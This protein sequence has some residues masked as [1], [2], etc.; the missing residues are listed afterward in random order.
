M[1]APVGPILPSWG[2]VG[3]I[4]VICRPWLDGARGGLH[5]PDLAQT[6]LDRLDILLVVA[7]LAGLV[8]GGEALVRGAVSLARG[9]GISPAVIGLTL[10]G[11]GTSSPELLTSLQA[12]VAGSAGIAIGNVVGSNT[13]NSL[14]IVGVAAMLAPIA[15]APAVLR[16]D[17]LVMVAAT[18]ACLGA[19]L[20]AQ[21]GRAVGVAFLAGMFVYLVATIRAERRHASP[22]ATMYQHEAE[23]IPGPAGG[24]GRS[25]LALLGGLALTL[26]GARFLVEGAVSLAET[27][28]MSE[29]VI[30][31]TIVAVGTSMPELVTSVIAA[32]KGHGDV[33]LGNIVGSNIFN[34]L[35]IL[36]VTAVIVPLPVP[37]EIA[38]FDIWVMLAATLLLMLFARTGWRIGRREGTLLLIAYA[39]YATWRLAGF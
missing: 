10:V 16:R 6:G 7:G 29:A 17:G 9:A 34:I 19:V 21:I 23:T 13:G 36:G 12:A 8:L 20:L 18:L 25:L 39:V 26:L 27:L 2:T 1:P 31:L 28:G 11:F 32:R 3:S 14:L 35:G 38:A 30:G 15:V 37:P 24:T 33:A 22:A 4:P 5:L